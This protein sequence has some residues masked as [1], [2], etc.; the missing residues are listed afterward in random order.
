MAQG[1]V[2]YFSLIFHFVS[3]LP[4]ESLYEYDCVF[5]ERASP[6]LGCFPSTA[7]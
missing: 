1:S 2:K 7:A 4:V 3:I 5:Q 6:F